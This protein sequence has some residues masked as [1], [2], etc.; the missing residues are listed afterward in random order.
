MK[1]L[2]AY[3]LPDG[4]SEAIYPAIS[5]VNTFRTIFNRYFGGNLPLLEDRSYFSPVDDPFR[6]TPIP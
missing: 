6:L 5:P 1:I 2:N 4:G 3:Y